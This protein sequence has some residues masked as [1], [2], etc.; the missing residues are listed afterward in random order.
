MTDDATFTAPK[1]LINLQTVSKRLG[2]S[3]ASKFITFDGQ[4]VGTLTS[5][6]K[7][8]VRLFIGRIT[9]CQGHRAYHESRSLSEVASRLAIL[10]TNKLRRSNPDADWGPLTLDASPGELKEIASGTRTVLRYPYAHRYSRVACPFGRPIVIL[11]MSGTRE[12]KSRTEATLV[13]VKKVPAA[14]AHAADPRLDIRYHRASS[15][16]E[17]TFE[18]VAPAADTSTASP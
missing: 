2:I 13:S 12:G 1:P 4:T 15:F 14:V 18:L 6:T 17:V 10:L 5:E 16:A 9:D 11:N 8:G 3:A 7:D